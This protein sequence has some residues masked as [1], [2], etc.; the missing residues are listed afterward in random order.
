MSHPHCAPPCQTSSEQKLEG[1]IETGTVGQ[2]VG[3]QGWGDEPGGH[4]DSLLTPWG[5]SQR[6]SASTK[7]FGLLFLKP[8]FTEHTAV[9][10]TGAKDAAMNKT[11][12]VP[13]FRDF[14]FWM[15]MGGEMD[16]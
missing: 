11:S 14:M 8:E 12:R 10:G 15:E 13:V 2:K 3:C 9:P 1:L 16:T 5:P 4:P 7:P 6:R